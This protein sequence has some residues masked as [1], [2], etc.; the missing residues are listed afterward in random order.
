MPDETMASAIS[1]MR[2]SLTLQPNLFQ[3]FHPIGGVAAS[4]SYS[5]SVKGLNS[6]SAFDFFWAEA[7]KDTRSEAATSKQAFKLVFIASKRFAVDAKV[8]K[9]INQ[10]LQ[11]SP[12]LYNNNRKLDY[13]DD[14]PISRNNPS[15]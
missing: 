11:K 10:V 7:L 9:C 14:F 12:S 8:E 4:D 13:M 1:L 3:L 6:G 2:V 15:R 5:S